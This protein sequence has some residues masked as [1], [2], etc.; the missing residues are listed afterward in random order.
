MT[1]RRHRRSDRPE[2]EVDRERAWSH[3]LE[4]PG[5]IR[6]RDRF[7][8]TEYDDKRLGEIAREYDQ[9]CRRA[10]GRIE[11]QVTETDVL[12]AL[13]VINTLRDKLL[14]DELMLITLAR[15]YGVT[16]TR[17][18]DA[19]ELKS[20]Q[21]AERRHLQLSKS[22][23]ADGIRPRTQNERV[24]ATR[25]RR[26]RRAERDWALTNAEAIRT[27]ALALT[28]IPDLQERANC[29]REGMLM[30]APVGEDGVDQ[31]P[32]DMA[33]PSALKEC[34]TEHLRFRE[35]P[36]AYLNTDRLAPGDEE[37][38]LVQQQG[39]IV[40]RMLGLLRYAADPRH[41]DLSDYPDLRQR[42]A[43]LQD[44]AIH[45]RR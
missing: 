8:L 31:G 25:E 37:W 4:N 42:V 36:W 1:T 30:S 6:R 26:R 40:H 17:I 19:L 45:N 18:A 12:A 34:L 5:G 9:I 39:D 43:N 41:L 23:S 44:S 24:E 3:M 20:R 21:S 11:P 10:Q 14:D 2:A 33:W 16:W 38:Q 15:T 13:L 27:T 22:T 7:G 29:S 28:E 32:V 35:D